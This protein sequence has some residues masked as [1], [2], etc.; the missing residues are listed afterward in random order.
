MNKYRCT[1]AG[2]SLAFVLSTSLQSVFAS[3]LSSPR[4]IKSAN[5]KKT[6][7]SGIDAVIKD[8]IE[9]KQ[10]AGAVV[11]L[12]HDNKIVYRKAFGERSIE[13][14]HEAMTLDTIFDIASLTKVVA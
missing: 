14:K 3:N 7:F 5:S 13:P 12:G 2:L 1:L 11:L 10:I 4:K 8:A 9:S 6:D